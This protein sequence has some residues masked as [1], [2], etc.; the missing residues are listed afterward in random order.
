MPARNLITFRKGTSSEWSS[1]AVVLA[2][3]EPGYEIDTGKFK[4]GNGASGWNNLNYS[5]VVPTGLLG[6]SG[7]TVTLGTNGSSAT[8]GTNNTI[9]KNTGNQQISGLL[10]IDNIWIDNNSIRCFESVAGGV[11]IDIPKNLII[12]PDFWNSDHAPEYSGFTTTFLGS[13]GL[14]TFDTYRPW[15]YQ[16][17]TVAQG[18]YS[19]KL[20]IGG[21]NDVNQGNT[22]PGAISLENNILTVR[23]STIGSPVFQVIGDSGINIGGQISI[24]DL[25]TGDQNIP[26]SLGIGTSSPRGSLDVIGEI[27]NSGNCFLNSLEINKNAV[28][29]NASLIINS[30]NIQINGSGDYTTVITSSGLN[31]IDLDVVLLTVD[32]TDVYSTTSTDNTFFLNSSGFSRSALQTKGTFGAP[33]SPGDTLLLQNFVDKTLNGLYLVEIVPSLTLV[34]LIRKSPFTNGSFIPNQTRIKSISNNSIYILNSTSIGNSTI[35]TDE[36]IFTKDSGLTAMT[37]QSNTDVDF[38]GTISATAKFFKIQHPDPDSQYKTLQYGSLE[39]PYNGVRLTGCGKLKKGECKIILPSYMKY[40]I[41]EEDINIQLT[42]KGH[43][44]ILYIDSI[45]L[46]SNS[47]IVKGYRSK[48]GGP[49]EFYWSFTGIRKDVP[50]LVAEQ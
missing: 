20:L 9:L 1:A 50:L 49:Y 25:P 40:L 7:I 34:R 47:F 42:N 17:N 28:F 14:W 15:Q 44:K 36:L 39:S 45:D 6:V 31:V 4:I 26:A 18:I 16:I 13:S 38:A 22:A 41:H 24:S 29:N 3:G 5:C 2:S 21:V 35:G 43:H 12:N 30:G 46:D 8:I 19:N 48:T 27:Y 23:E 11:D 10:N 33:I 37:I 32:K